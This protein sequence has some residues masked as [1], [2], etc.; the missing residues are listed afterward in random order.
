MTQT[1]ELTGG[2]GF[3]FEGTVVASYLGSLLTEAAPR[4]LLGRKTVHIAVQQAAFGEPLDDLVVDADAPDGTTARISLQIKSSLTISAAQSNVDF[5]E[6]VVNSWKTINQDK[7]RD[8][9]DRV[10]AAVGSVSDAAAHALERVCGLARDST[11]PKVF[12]DRFIPGAGTGQRLRDIVDIFRS[13]LGRE[14]GKSPSDEDIHRL[15]RHFTIL[16]FDLLHEGARDEASAIEALRPNLHPDDA[17]KADDLWYRLRVIAHEAAGHAGDFTRN[18]LL[19]HLVGRFRLAGALSLR[20]D[21]EKLRATAVLALND[22]GATIEGVE[23]ER[24]RLAALAEQEAKSRRFVQFLGLPGSGKSAVLRAVA[25]NRSAV[26]SVIVLKSDRL[27]GSSWPEYATSIGLKS[28]DVEPL[29][30][31]LTATGSPTLVVDGLDKIPL[32]SRG[33]VTDLVKTILQ[34]PTLKEWRIMVSLRDSGS[35]HL[36]TWLPDNLFRHGGVATIDVAGFDDDEASSL[37]ASLPQMRPLLFAANERVREMARRPFFVNVLA[38]SMR[39]GNPI[40]ASTE[41][42]LVDAWWRRGGYAAE[43]ADTTRRQRALA[44]LAEQGAATLGRQMRSDGV[45]A[46]V[47]NDLITDGI[48]T[49]IRAGHTIKFA[50]DIFFEWSFLQILIRRGRDWC[51]GIRN[52]GEPPVLGR[53]VELLSQLTFSTDDDWE[54]HL[55]SIEN[56][57]LRP[58]WTRAWLFGPFGA[59]TFTDNVAVFDNAVFQDSAR[60]FA[61]LVVW[62]QAEKTRANPQVLD[63]T[64]VREG[65]SRLEIVRIAN[66]IAWPSDLS[67]WRQFCRWLLANIPQFPIETISNIVSVFEIWQNILVDYKNPI[68]QRIVKTAADWLYDIEDRKHPEKYSYNPGPWE[69]LK[70]NEVDELERRLRAIVLRAARTLPDVVRTYLQ[71][72]EKRPHLRHHSFAEI[73]VFTPTLVSKHA[74]ELVDICFV[75]LLGILPT[76]KVERAESEDRIPLPEFY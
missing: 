51:G 42:D 69:A 10:G 40:Q 45:D 6:I 37:A 47:L 36:R 20:G 67:L 14:I 32:P 22:I 48:L 62:F 72:I 75:E 76:R 66:D 34:S 11:T 19:Q 57:G 52:A 21:I 29:L 43:G 30:L 31:E 18:T 73:I 17:S 27:V 54:G 60:R 5:R 25:I 26:G 68:S 39:A 9:T 4:G 64:L 50:H 65:L 38:R 56:A 13:I 58:Q 46:N 12:A 35:E 49:E 24:T 53:V 59:A 63:G 23:V 7:F 15:L 44:G 33:I 2:A 74:K 28:T 55:R 16:R 1:S 41:I 70:R 71:R 61:K 3:T 8:G